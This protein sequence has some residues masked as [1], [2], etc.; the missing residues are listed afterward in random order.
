MGMAGEGVGEEVEGVSLES[1]DSGRS[2][3]S[4]SGRSTPK[5]PQSR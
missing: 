4:G 2:T 1:K 5:T 3:D